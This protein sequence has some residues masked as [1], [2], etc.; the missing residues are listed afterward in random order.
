MVWTDNEHPETE[1][2]LIL[3]AEEI[4]RCLAAFDRLSSPRASQR[5]MPKAVS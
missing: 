4:P 3:C 1:S 5:L 2:I